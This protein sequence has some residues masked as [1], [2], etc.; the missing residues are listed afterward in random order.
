MWWLVTFSGCESC[1]VLGSDWVVVL[2]TWDL[3]VELEICDCV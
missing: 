2:G 3:V 1:G